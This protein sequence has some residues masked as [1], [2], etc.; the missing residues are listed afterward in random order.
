MEVLLKV[1]EILSHPSDPSS[2]RPHPP[3]PTPISSE[4]LFP[5]HARHAPTHTPSRTLTPSS[6]RSWS[7][8]TS[9]PFRPPSLSVTASGACCVLPPPAP[10]PARPPPSCS[11]PSPSGAVTVA[12]EVIAARR[13]PGEK[14]RKMNEYGEKKQ[15][16]ARKCE[17]ERYQTKKRKKTSDKRRHIL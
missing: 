1:L 5:S 11:L 10:A 13:R 3:T 7:P 15:E 12:G 6:A 9:P 8:F 17:M 16:R 2:F 14:E 4:T